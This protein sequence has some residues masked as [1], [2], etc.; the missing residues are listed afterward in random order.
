MGLYENKTVPNN[1]YIAYG[2]E[3]YS[4][5][6]LGSQ[7]KSPRNFI[8]LRTLPHHVAERYEQGRIL[9]LLI[10]VLMDSL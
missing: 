9:K 8:Y 5:F 10:K 7:A 6:C 2:L 3:F 4:V 1:R